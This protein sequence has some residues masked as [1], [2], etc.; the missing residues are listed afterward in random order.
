LVSPSKGN[1]ILSQRHCF[2]QKPGIVN[3]VNEQT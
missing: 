1:V 3:L 2:A